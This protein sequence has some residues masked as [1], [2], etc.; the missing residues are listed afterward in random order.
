MVT[1]CS[2]YTRAQ[3][4]ERVSAW[5]WGPTRYEKEAPAAMPSGLPRGISVS[6]R[7]GGGPAAS[8]KKR[9]GMKRLVIALA[10]AVAGSLA[11]Y[12]QGNRSATL[13]TTQHYLG[14]ERVRD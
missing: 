9:T 7:R 12:R 4:C 13:P 1:F 2:G 5:G 14:W 8:A 10:V 3:R 11:L 6:S